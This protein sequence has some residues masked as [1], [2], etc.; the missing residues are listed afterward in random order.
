MK[1][2]KSAA[3]LN[4]TSTCIA[5]LSVECVKVNHGDKKWCSA[6]FL[7]EDEEISRSIFETEGGMMCLICFFHILSCVVL[8]QT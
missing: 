4:S 1:M 3:A 5:H 6:E 8:Q 7:L 2:R